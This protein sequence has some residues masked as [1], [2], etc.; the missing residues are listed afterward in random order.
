MSRLGAKISIKRKIGKKEK[1]KR[2]EIKGAKEKEN[3][4]L[5]VVV[6]EI[7]RLFPVL[8]GLEHLRLA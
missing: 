3:Q 6:K 4:P 2:S 7:M 8:I 1:K 5:K